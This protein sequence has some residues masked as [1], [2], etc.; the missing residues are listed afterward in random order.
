MVYV[1]FYLIRVGNSLVIKPYSFFLLPYSRYLFTFMNIYRIVLF[2]GFMACFFMLLPMA[3][4]QKKE[5]APKEEVYEPVSLVGVKGGSLSSFLNISPSVQQGVYGGFTGGAFWNYFAE[6]HLGFRFEVSVSQMGWLELPKVDGLGIQSLGG[7]TRNLTLVETPLLATLSMGKGK[8]RPFVNAGFYM[9][10]IALETFQ[11]TVAGTQF[12][13]IYRNKLVD[14]Q[15]LTGASVG[16]GVEWLIGKSRLGAEVRYI[17]MFTHLL[18]RFQN[19]SILNRETNVALELRERYQTSLLNAF[20]FTVHY[21]F[22]IK[23][24]FKKKEGAKNDKGR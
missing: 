3:N 13:R 4:G 11:N 12:E 10:F 23:E 20:Q 17:T 5:A 9:G 6:K 1:V 21:S 7:H 14:R 18:E 15:L 8:V 2:F 16:A 24:L 19:Q 22:E